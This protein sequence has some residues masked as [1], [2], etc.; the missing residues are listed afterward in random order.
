MPTT[1]NTPLY[2]HTWATVDLGALEHNYLVVRR[3]LPPSV[4]IMAMVKADAYGHGALPVARV[5]EEAGSQAFGVATAEE[6]IELRDGGIKRPIVVMGG[7]LGVGLVASKAMIAARLTP[8]IHSRDAIESLEVEAAKEGLKVACHLKVDTGMTRL[9][10]RLEA[11]PSLVSQ[12]KQC[13]HVFVEGVMTHL[14]EGDNP[15]VS[16]RQVEVFLSSKRII[17]AALGPIRIWHIANSAACLRGEPIEVDGAKENW[18]RP[19]LALYGSCNGVDFLE[20]E[21]KPVMGLV[22]RVALLKGVTAGTRVSYGGTFT[23]TRPSRLAVIPIGYADGYPWSLSNRA[24]VLIRGRRVAVVG[25]VTMDM[26][27]A[28]VT[29]LNGVGVGDEVVLLGAQG[30]ECIGLSELSSLASTIPYEMLCGIS[31]RIPRI[32][33]DRRA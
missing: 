33:K 25:R 19:G 28:D 11:L 22:S 16:S 1:P 15:E 13:R 20:D 10:V 31:K 14:S 4:G 23:T 8:V 6:G 24:N 5:L 18:V 32:Y 9:G 21:L 7:L 27:M 12:I 17:E 29:D 3:H 2:R 26:I 30:D